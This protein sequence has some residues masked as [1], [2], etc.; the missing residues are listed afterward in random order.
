M[1]WAEHSTSWQSYVEHAWQLEGALSW[2][3]DQASLWSFAVRG[4]AAP[5][6]VPGSVARRGRAKS[7]PARPPRVVEVAD[8]DPWAIQDSNLGPLPY[9]ATPPRRRRRRE[10]RPSQAFSPVRSLPV[11]AGLGQTRRGLG[12]NTALLPIAPAIATRLSERRP[13]S[14]STMY[15]TSPAP[16]WPTPLAASYTYRTA[17]SR[18]MEYEG[19][20]C[21]WRV[22]AGGAWLVSI[23][24]FAIGGFI[25]GA[26]LAGDLHQLA[27]VALGAVVALGPG[28][29]I[30]AY[31]WRQ[32]PWDRL[33]LDRLLTYEQ[34]DGPQDLNTMIRN[35]DFVQAC[36]VL[37]RAKLNPYAGRHVPPLSDAPDLDLQLLVGRSA[38]WHPADSPE[39]FVQIRECLR[40]AGIRARIAGQDINADG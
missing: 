10:C 30:A 27:L 16:V 15:A 33:L 36:H 4:L 40:A 28:Q 3:S 19:R 13:T 22:A 14:V 21:L 7:R 34:I 39:T 18:L 25:G 23:P 24:A 12:S 2:G 6:D 8:I 35:H 38:C 5:H 26:Y 29:L 11:S 17:L 37:R 20:S 1:P 31:L 9:Q 32:R